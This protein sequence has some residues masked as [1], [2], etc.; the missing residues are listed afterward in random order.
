M[1]RYTIYTENKNNEGIRYILDSHLSCYSI[2]TQLGVWNKQDEPSLRIE[3]IGAYQDEVIQRICGEIKILN[4]QE[5]ILLTCE[6]LENS[7]LI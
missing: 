1:V 2:Q 7:W 4:K 5:S 3:I 6:R